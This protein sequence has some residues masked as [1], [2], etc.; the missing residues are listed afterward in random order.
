MLQTHFRFDEFELD[1]ESCELRRSGHHIRLERIPMQLLVLLLENPGKLVR[2]EVIVERLW[3][4]NIF[5]E[6]EHSINTA[7]NKLRAILRDDSRNP[8][9]IRTVIGQGYCFIA[10]V[11]APQQS[12]VATPIPSPE[13]QDALNNVP[14][15][16]SN[17]HSVSPSDQVELP[18]L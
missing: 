6:A 9:F 18:V 7:V 10:D 15:V 4:K 2:R 11:T 1:T 12:V 8:R 16:T 13:P 17:G 3:G 14:P 5:V